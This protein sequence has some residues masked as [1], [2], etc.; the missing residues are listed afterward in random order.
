ME[1]FRV[2]VGTEP[3]T[4]LAEEVLVHSLRRH[5]HFPLEVTPLIGPEWDVPDDLPSGTGF[6]L[7][8]FLIPASLGYQGF[9]LYLD[10]DIL[11]LGGLDPL[12]GKQEELRQRGSPCA[13]TRQP[14][15]LHPRP[16]WQSS[17][18]LLNAA[19]WKAHPPEWFFDRL[20][21]GYPYQQIMRL[22]FWPPGQS[23]LPLANSWNSF[24]KVPPG[25]RLVHFTRVPTQPWVHPGHS[26]AGLWREALVEAI[27][28]GAVRP[29]T[30]AQAVKLWDGTAR[31]SGRRDGLHPS[32]HGLFPGLSP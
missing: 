20:R 16:T 26:L 12:L 1:P 13:A 2:F 27:A 5:T 29:E 19:A 22:G 30:F 28:A 3:R 9:G 8:R 4:R 7:R 24:E 18:L 31:K 14:D 17:V 15:R 32:Y 25:T 23:P 6:S 21:H 11:A 10:A